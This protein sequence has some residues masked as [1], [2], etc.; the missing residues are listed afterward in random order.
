MMTKFG[1][2]ISDIIRSETIRYKIKRWYIAPDDGPKCANIVI[3][4]GPSIIKLDHIERIH[5]IGNMSFVWSVLDK[6]WPKLTEI[7]LEIENEHSDDEL[8]I[9]EKFAGLKYLNLDSGNIFIH[10]SVC[11][12]LVELYADE[13]N[14]DAEYCDSMGHFNVAREQITTDVF[15]KL[16]KL[17]CRNMNLGAMLAHNGIKYLNLFNVSM[18]SHSDDDDQCA[19]LETLYLR[20]MVDSDVK[21]LWEAPKLKYIKLVDCQGIFDDG[22]FPD[23]MNGLETLIM[24]YTEYAEDEEELPSMPM[25]KKLIIK[26]CYTLADQDIR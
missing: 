11:S 18:L 3:R 23:T 14:F 4:P 20:G 6:Q 22:P 15:P 8:Y 25:I 24:K 16:L 19:N 12:T 10:H 7:T 2:A 21:I 5:V 26:E 17:T 9:G 1:K 13:I